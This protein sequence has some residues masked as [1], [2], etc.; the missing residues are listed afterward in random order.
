MHMHMHFDNVFHRSLL[1]IIKSVFTDNVS[2]SF[3]FTPFSQYWTTVDGRRVQ[4]YS[5]AY[6]SPWMVEAYKKVNRLPREAD[7]HYERVIIPLMLWSDTTHLTNFGDASLWPVYVYFGNQSKYIRGKPT[8][9]ACH[10]VAYIPSVSVYIVHTTTNVLL[11]NSYCS[12]P[13]TFKI[14]MSVRMAKHQHVRCILT[15]SM[16][17]CMQ[18]IWRHL[19]DRQFV[20]AFKTGILIECVDHITR[21]FFPHLFTYSANYPEKYKMFTVRARQ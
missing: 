1:D 4:V 17:L 14:R 6:T 21:C 20:K 8:S 5:E 15:S 16:S 12:Y 19:L 18:A 9:G 3:H 7:D 13:T 2:S 10:H 11:T